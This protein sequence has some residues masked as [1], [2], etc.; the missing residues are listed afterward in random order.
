[1]KVRVDTAYSDMIF[2]NLLYMLGYMYPNMEQLFFLRSILFGSE[3][4][5]VSVRSIQ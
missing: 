5:Q 4:F 3:T 2:K 1:M